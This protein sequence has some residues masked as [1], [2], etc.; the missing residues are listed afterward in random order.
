MLNLEVLWRPVSRK[1]V[2]TYWY[3]YPI[4]PI[5]PWAGMSQKEY[6]F[7]R[8]KKGFTSICTVSMLEKLG[9]CAIYF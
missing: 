1:K 2:A 3:K 6:T 9:K 7:E 8:A 5:K 4:N